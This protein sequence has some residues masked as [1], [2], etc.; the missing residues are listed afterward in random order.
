[1]GRGVSDRKWFQKLINP[2]AYKKV[3]FWT[4]KYG[5]AAAGIFRF[6]PGLRFPGHMACGALGIPAWKFILIDGFLVL[7]TI[8]TQ[9]YFI[10]HY[11]EEILIFMNRFKFGFMGIAVLVMLYIF[12]TIYTNV[13]YVA[14]R[15]KARADKKLKLENKI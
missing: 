14:Q 12:W 3:K 4:Q 15:N 10:A 9:V 11:G 1:L 13:E 5:S 2:K 6:L 7:L 8:P